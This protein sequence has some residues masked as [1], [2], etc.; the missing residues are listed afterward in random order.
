MLNRSLA[1]DEGYEFLC[2]GGYDPTWRR[3]GRTI[4]TPM[5]AAW[6]SLRES[7]QSETRGQISADATLWGEGGAQWA[8]LLAG[9]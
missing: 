8:G 1:A 3:A 2:C 9:L 4:F 6:Q 5:Q 7:V